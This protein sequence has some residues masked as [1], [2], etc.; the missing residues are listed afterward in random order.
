MHTPRAEVDRHHR[1]DAGGAGPAHELVEPERVRLDGLPGQVESARP[2]GDRTHAVLPAVSGDEVAARVPH[3][4][5]AQLTGEVE[6]VAPQAVLVGGGVRWLVHPAVDAPTHVLD[7]RSEQAPAD[8]PNPKC[9]IYAQLCRV[10]TNP[11]RRSC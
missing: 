8:R 2:V 6:D 11:S 7:E 1:L 5:H 4:R 10:H 9:R 3:H